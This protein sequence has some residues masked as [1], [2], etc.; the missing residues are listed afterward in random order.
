MEAV[1]LSFSGGVLGIV[2]AMLIIAG[3][4]LFSTV[5]PTVPWPTILLASGLSL[6]VGIF[7]GIIPAIQAARKDPI[8]A[9]RRQ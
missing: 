2:L 5:E 9:L 1:V 3:L 4:K 8:E 6:I 7:F